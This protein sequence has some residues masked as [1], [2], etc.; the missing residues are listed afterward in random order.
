MGRKKPKRCRI[1]ELLLKIGQN[2]QWLA[3]MS[4]YSRQRISNICNMRSI[5]GLEAARHLATIIGCMIDDLYEW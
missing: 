2:Q 4:G 3:D 1:P 5:L